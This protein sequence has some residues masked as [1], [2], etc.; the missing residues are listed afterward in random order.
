MVKS[1]LSNKIFYEENNWIEEEDEGKKTSLF[2]IILKDV[3]VVI[4][5]GELSKKWKNYNVYY[6]PVY[7]IISE[8]DI[9]QIGIYEI[10]AT[11]KDYYMDDDGDLN[12]SYVPGPL[13]FKNVTK[14]YLKKLLKN[15]TLIQDYGDDENTDE[16]KNTDDIKSI[17]N[18][19]FQ[20]LKIEDDDDKDYDDLENKTKDKQI[21]NEWIQ[22]PDHQPINLFLKNSYFDI[23]PNPGNG[24]CLFCTITQAFK[25]IGINL[26]INNMR[27]KLADTITTEQ[28]DTYKEL[29]SNF[30]NNYKTEVLEYKS[31]MEDG[32]KKTIE[33]KKLKCDLQNGK[34]DHVD[35]KPSDKKNI[36]D[37]CS[38]LKKTLIKISNNIKKKI[39]EIKLSEKNKKDVEWLKDI[40]NIQ[41]L[42]SKIKTNEFWADE[43]AINNLENIYKIKLIILTKN[44]YKDDINK[45]RVLNCGSTIHSNII[46][47]NTFKPKYYILIEYDEEIQ[48]YQLIK[49]KLNDKWF[50]IF[51]FHELPYSI[52]ELIKD[53]CLNNSGK[54]IFDYI[55]KFKKYIGEKPLINK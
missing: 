15:K 20:E 34:Y 37:K 45:N 35:I 31:L 13:L 21:R 6:W 8:D 12:I 25:T 41:D 23:L 38:D 52:K 9:K 29:Y 24:D 7:L 30:N 48:H 49:Y 14:G 50:S 42:K 5:L 44:Y 10:S 33:Y 55:P 39:K 1:K 46:N 11:D 18:N 32:K 43:N 51:R 40:D 3:P 22:S 26:N 54:T 2:Q 28:F 4:A 47:N 27:K 19:I 16:Q 17:S 36:V 53:K